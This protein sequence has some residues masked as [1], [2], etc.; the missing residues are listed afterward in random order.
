MKAYPLTEL[1][2]TTLGVI[3]GASALFFALGGACTGFWVSI[4][5]SI[6]FADKGTPEKVLSYWQGLETAA[7]ITAAGLMALGVA[8]FWFSSWKVKQIKRETGHD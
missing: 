5:Q 1:E 7:L 6:A 2:L 4:K 8:A 3:Q